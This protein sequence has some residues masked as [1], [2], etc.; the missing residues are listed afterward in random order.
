MGIYCKEVG[1]TWFHSLVYNE[2]EKIY[3]V[4]K[5]KMKE[6]E[7]LTKTSNYKEIVY[8]KSVNTELISTLFNDDINHL[9]KGY[10]LLNCR[11]S[12]KGYERR[13]RNLDRDKRDHLLKAEVYFSKITRE[14]RKTLG[15]PCKLFR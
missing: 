9:G 8:I 7:Q 11:D 12:P 3:N 6:M 14:K 4:I 5:Y 13:P 15:L 1:Q 2:L 10:V